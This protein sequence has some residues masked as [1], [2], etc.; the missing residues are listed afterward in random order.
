MGIISKSVSQAAGAVKAFW[1]NGA[2]LDQPVGS[3]VPFGFR[4]IPQIPRND[5]VRNAQEGFSRNEL[6][7]AC[8]AAGVPVTK[9][10]GTLTE[11]EA[12]SVGDAVL[13]HTARICRVVEYIE[14]HYDGPLYTFK[15]AYR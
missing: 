9:S 14:S 11:I 7:Y 13:S 1:P 6:V 2:T 8:F 12:L 5:Y 4:D 3:T 10:D 15:R